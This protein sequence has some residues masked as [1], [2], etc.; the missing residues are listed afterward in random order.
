MSYIVIVKT[1]LITYYLFSVFV[2]RDHPLTIKKRFLSVSFMLIFSPLYTWY[3]I[4]DKTKVR[5]TYYKIVFI[6]F[7]N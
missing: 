6:F 7:L 4:N 3:L 1:Y 2:L 5:H